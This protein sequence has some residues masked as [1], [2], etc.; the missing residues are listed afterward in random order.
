MNN[1]DYFKISKYAHVFFVFLIT[2]LLFFGSTNNTMAEDGSVHD[3]LIDH[4]EL[5]YH[6]DECI[7]N[8]FNSNFHIDTSNIAAINCKYAFKDDGL[9]QYIMTE[10][11]PNKIKD[12][13]DQNK[14]DKKIDSYEKNTNHQSLWRFVDDDYT[15]TGYNDG[16]E[17]GI[18]AFNVIQDAIDYSNSGDTIFVH[19]GIYQ[20]KISTFFGYIT[21]R[22]DKSLTLI[23]EDKNHTIIDGNHSR[24]IEVKTSSVTIKDFTIRNASDDNNCLFDNG[25]AIYS[26]SQ[27]HLSIKDINIT[28]CI[29]TQNSESIQMLSSTSNVKISNCYFHN[30]SDI[31]IYSGNGTSNNISIENCVMECNGKSYGAFFSTGGIFLF[32]H[33]NISITNC[34]SQLNV[35]FGIGVGCKNNLRIANN[36]LNNNSDC[37]IFTGGYSTYNNIIEHNELFNN[38]I[39]DE[40]GLSMMTG[41]ILLQDARNF[42]IRWNNIFSNEKGCGISYLRSFDNDIF[43]NNIY[44]NLYN[45]FFLENEYR[46]FRGNHWNNNYWDDWNGRGLKIIQGYV[47][48]P[49]PQD[50]YNYVRWCHFAMNPAEE[51]NDLY[52]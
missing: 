48:F 9:H 16:H 40:P 20:D 1:D 14:N 45:A 27:S 29:F 22:I 11:L 21:C 23:G 51:P 12:Y 39:F 26:P 31:S 28:D 36:I 7:V 10:K 15:P 25:I 3:P 34:I 52:Y 6:Y 37:G 30:N 13:T 2:G 32:S 38:G 42:V 4:G 41:G 8:T 49:L 5:N 33:S 24:I 43:E 44:N 50:P 18:D 17:W 19:N 47:D 35:G 46:F